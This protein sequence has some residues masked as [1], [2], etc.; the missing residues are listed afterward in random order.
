M[1]NYEFTYC[2]LASS[3]TSQEKREE[4][5]HHLKHCFITVLDFPAQLSNVHREGRFARAED[6]GRRK[7]LRLGLKVQTLAKNSVLR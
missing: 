7:R 4:P 2:H 6:W 1:T 3:F 5:R